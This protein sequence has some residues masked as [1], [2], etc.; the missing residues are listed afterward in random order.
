M[1]LFDNMFQYG[2]SESDASTEPPTRI[3]DPSPSSPGDGPVC[4]V[5]GT[6]VNYSGRG[7][8]PKYCDEH[9]TRTGGSG[10]RATNN[11]GRERK[12]KSALNDP[13]LREIAE[14][15]NKGAGQFVGMVA[16]VTPVTAA[17][18]VINAPGAIDAVVK[19]AADN[20]KMLEGLEFVARTMP[21][22]ECGKFAASLGYAVM[23]DMGQANPYGLA[24]EYLGVARA[25]AEVGWQPPKPKQPQQPGQPA[26]PNNAPSAPPPFT[27]V[28]GIKVRN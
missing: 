11:Q 24:G 1:G 14:D 13:R 18:I 7:R 6:P 25:A 21:W 2:G 4:D 8:P 28:P 27:L 23:V 12:R 16:P 15:L 5:C 22:L 9:K 17:T 19:L 20:P 3:T 10:E 26:Q